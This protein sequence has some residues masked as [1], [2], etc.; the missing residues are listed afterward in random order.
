MLFSTTPTALKV[1]RKLKPEGQPEPLQVPGS[2]IQHSS[3]IDQRHG[4]FMTAIAGFTS[5]LLGDKRNFYAAYQPSMDLYVQA[6]A[7]A[8]Q[9]EAPPVSDAKAPSQ[10]GLKAPPT[11]TPASPFA[12][13][14]SASPATNK[15][16]YADAALPPTFQT[17][18]QITQLH[19]WMMMVRFRALDKSLGRHYQQQITNHFFND[20]EARLRVVYQIRDGRIIQTYMKDLLLQ[21]R[22]S[23]VAYDE[24]L[25]SSDAVLAAALWRN[26]YGAKADFPL[27][28][29]AS[30]SAH[31]RK[32]L[33]KLD[34]APDEQVLSGKF[35]F[36]APK[37]LA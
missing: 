16:W 32:Q 36:D 3:Q 2:G 15:F 13:T 5:K 33:V 37:P 26:M 21:W 11:M 1:N 34:N 35:V 31:V 29:L 20:A 10:A 25:C 4:S 6:A 19:I 9:Q 30:M 14:S 17:W 12:A 23:I 22:G 24:A 27:T 8:A 28:S 18:F 7:Q